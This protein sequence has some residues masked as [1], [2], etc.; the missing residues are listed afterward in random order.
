ME[1]GDISS[2]RGTFDM[3]PDNIYYLILKVNNYELRPIILTF[4][5]ED[6][7]CQTRQC[8]PNDMMSEGNVSKMNKKL[9]WRK[10]EK[11]YN[12]RKNLKK[13]AALFLPGDITICPVTSE[14]DIS[15]I[16][17]EHVTWMGQWHSR[18]FTW[19]M[20]FLNVLC[21]RQWIPSLLNTRS[22]P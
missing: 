13:M 4:R 20:R 1:R 3:S 11:N 2:Q 8:I 10:Y 21:C 5:P 18:K 16:L 9:K 17:H 12:L 6:F 19:G 7:L 15:K 22:R 14:G